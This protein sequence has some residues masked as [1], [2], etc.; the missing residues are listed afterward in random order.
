MTILI[1]AGVLLL[2]GGAYFAFFTEEPLI[3]LSDLDTPTPLVPPDSVPKNR[4]EMLKQRAQ[5]EKDS[6]KLAR[7]GDSYWDSLSDQL[8]KDSIDLL[9]NEVER[10]QPVR[11]E[12]PKS[13]KEVVIKYVEVPVNK[14]VAVAR[15]KPKRRRSGFVS[16][17]EKIVT[18]AVNRNPN[19]V[20]G[21][22]NTAALIRSDEYL[23]AIVHDDQKVRK[24]NT[25]KLRLLEEG[26]INGIKLEKNR[27][28]YGVATLS[29]NRVII[30]V[31]SVVID[32]QVMEMNLTAYDTDGLQGV[33]IPGAIDKEIKDD[34]LNGVV[35]ETA[36]RVNIPL[37]GNLGRRSASKK[38]K[39]PVVE[40]PNGHEIILR[41][42]N[43]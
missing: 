27:F 3:Q 16:E 31:K 12:A 2:G 9:T 32:G 30:D 19:R 40:I 37:V 34:A 33:Y 23:K 1:M 15:P 35:S 29:N 13:D 38:I 7:Q 18:Y 21:G 25:V 6:L 20:T 17:S 41:V 43:K 24:D 5:R 22:E 42:I 8:E 36:S 26:Y 14:P 11:N 10:D 4:I 28:L 39:N